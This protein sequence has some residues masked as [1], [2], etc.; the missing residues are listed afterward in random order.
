MDKLTPIAQIRALV[1]PLRDI[2]VAVN[3]ACDLLVREE[4]ARREGG[5]EYKKFD[6]EPVDLGEAVKAYG[7]GLGS[8]AAIPTVRFDTTAV[9]G[10]EAQAPQT[11]ADDLPQRLLE[12]AT[13]YGASHIQRTI[14]EAA[15]RIET[16]RKDVEAACMNAIKAGLVLDKAEAERDALKAR[17]ARL[18]GLLLEAA[19][20]METLA[21]YEFNFGEAQYADKY[22][23][24]AKEIAALAGKT[25]V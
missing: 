19:G 6:R 10:T 25:N 23:E 14:T 9:P 12:L 5:T 11:D 24:L 15:A 1:Y 21:S 3:R 17:V 4:A 18:E 16:Q 20:S 13:A 8:A 7:E 22:R 2:F